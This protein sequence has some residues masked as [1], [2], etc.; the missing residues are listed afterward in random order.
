MKLP[1]LLLI[2]ALSIGCASSPSQI[3]VKIDPWIGQTVTQLV[4]AWGPP[5]QVFDLPDGRIYSWISGEGSYTSTQ[6][7]AVNVAQPVPGCRFD[8]TISPD[9]VVRSYRW[10]GYC[11]V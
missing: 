9:G 10:S 11:K 1:A 5:S 3:K 7:G 8:F 6:I 4:G 2:A